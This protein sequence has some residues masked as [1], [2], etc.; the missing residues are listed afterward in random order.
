MRGQTS[1]AQGRPLFHRLRF[2][3]RTSAGPRLPDAWQRRLLC[4][5]ERKR[6]IVFAR[7]T[8]HRPGDTSELIGQRHSKD[9]LMQS[10]GCRDQPATET[11]FLPAI[12][13]LENRTGA[14][15]EQ[16]A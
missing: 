16:G 13:P 2:L 9:I 3:S 12:G 4:R 6:G 10:L 15:N 1:A 5:F 8:E 7:M 11:F 14:L